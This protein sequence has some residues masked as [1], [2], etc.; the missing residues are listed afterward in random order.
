MSTRIR[1]PLHA[2]VFPA[3]LLL[4]YFIFLLFLPFFALDLDV[5]CFIPSVVGIMLSP[6]FRF[7]L[8]LAYDMHLVRTYADLIVLFLSEVRVNDLFQ[9]LCINILF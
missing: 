7:L 8:R 6:R 9:S 1:F 2:V 3:F 5:V 4:V